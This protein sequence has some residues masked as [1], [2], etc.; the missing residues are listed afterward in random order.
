LFNKFSYFYSKEKYMQ[1]LVFNTTTKT[2]KL[3]EGIAEKTDLIAHYTDVPTVKILDEGYYQVM[4]RDAMEKQLPV[5][6]VP[7]ANT[8]M[9]IKE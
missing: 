8:N 6:R 3:Y 2:A 5:L 4:Q 9:F 1:T 7:I